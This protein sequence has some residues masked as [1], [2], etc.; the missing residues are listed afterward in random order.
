MVLT[1]PSVCELTYF[2]HG[3]RVRVFITVDIYGTRTLGLRI[4]HRAPDGRMVSQWS[5]WHG[6]WHHTARGSLVCLMHYSGRNSMAHAH[7]FHRLGP[8]VYQIWQGGQC[9]VVTF[10]MI[11]L[12][13][14]QQQLEDDD[15]AW[16]F[17]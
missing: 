14:T 4:Q 17:L 11:T 10:R 12:L 3:A 8:H 6:D 15:R 7:T 9:I 1:C 5:G 2:R 13:L 16:E